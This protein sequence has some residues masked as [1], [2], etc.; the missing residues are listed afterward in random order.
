MNSQPHH[1]A[2]LGR[3]VEPYASESQCWLTGPPGS[4][5]HWPGPAAPQALSVPEAAS[6]K[7]STAE[8]RFPI[9]SPAH[10]G[11]ALPGSFRI[12]YSLRLDLQ[13]SLQ[14]S[15]VNLCLHGVHAFLRPEKHQS[16]AGISALPSPP[17]PLPIL[18]WLDSAFPPHCQPPCPYSCL[19][20]METMLQP[21]PAMEI[22]ADQR[23][24]VL[25]SLDGRTALCSH[26]R[27]PVAS[28]GIYMA[29][30]AQPSKA[31]PL[32]S[33]PAPGWVPITPSQDT[34]NQPEAVLAS[35]GL[36]EMADLYLLGAFFLNSYSSGMCHDVFIFQ[37]RWGSC[38]VWKLWLLP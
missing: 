16:P 7:L 30:L 28:K 4:C 6:L 17:C 27:P 8:H 26:L 2:T 32:I 15:R 23:P 5:Q 36:P 18:Q 21:Q 24:C 29:Q 10:W 13:G 9:S 37:T 12:T 1:Q 11:P 35:E 22:W 31:R 38:K 14:R 20:A 34:C 33:I 25:S 3:A 19:G